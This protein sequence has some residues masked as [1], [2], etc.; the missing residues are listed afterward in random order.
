MSDLKNIYYRIY[1]L[2]H[3]SDVPFEDIRERRIILNKFLAEKNK[4]DIFELSKHEA[5][6]LM[7]WLE[8][9]C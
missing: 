8:A 1:A 4:A 5:E 3:A 7:V 9:V 6:T 2:L